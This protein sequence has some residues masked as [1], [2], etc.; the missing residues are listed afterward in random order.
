MHPIT[1]EAVDKARALLLEYLKSIADR[2]GITQEEI[3]WRAGI[4]RANVNRIL[5]NKYAPSLD[6]L[7]K[8]LYALDSYPIIDENGSTKNIVSDIEQA[9][10]KSRKQG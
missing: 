6:T 1:D 10:Y 4:T 7:I 3:A 8:L 9:I 2:K 5:Q